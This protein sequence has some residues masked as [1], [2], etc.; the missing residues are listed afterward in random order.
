MSNEANLHR[1]EELLE[2]AHVILRKSDRSF[3][4]VS[5]MEL[6]AP[7]DG[8]DCDGYCLATDIEN[9]FEEIGKPLSETI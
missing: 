3:F 4:V 7:Y 8:T 2:A 5:A 1:A 6:T 9:W